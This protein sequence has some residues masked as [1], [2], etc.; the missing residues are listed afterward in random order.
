MNEKEEE[1]VLENEER[2]QDESNNEG[3]IIEKEIKPKNNEDNENQNQ[4][5]TEHKNIIEEGSK[6]S[7]NID[8]KEILEE[9]INENKI[10]EI[11]ND[12]N[13][14]N[15]ENDVKQE[16]KKEI[17]VGILDEIENKDDENDKKDKLEI[18]E[19][20]E[21]IEKNEKKDNDE[22]QIILNI[23]ED[24]IKENNEIQIA[25]NLEKKENNENKENNE[26][27][28]NIDIKENEMKDNNEIKINDN[29]EK[30]KK[31]KNEKNEN[32]EK[33]INI[34][35]LLEEL[36]KKDEIIEKM[37]NEIKN[38]NEEMTKIKEANKKNSLLLK[39]YFE[40]DM[41]SIKEEIS[42]MKNNN[43]EAK[44]NKKNP[45]RK[46]DFDL[47]KE[48]LRDL[49][50]KYN[51]FE[52]VFDNKL[53]FIESSLSK[54]LK[55]EGPQKEE[56]K[57]EKKINENKNQIVEN[58]NKINENKN[59]IVENKN[60]ANV[61][62]NNYINK[63]KPYIWNL[64]DEDEEIWKEFFNFLDVHF[65]EK[66]AK[67]KEIKKADLE[68]F[69]KISLNLIKNGKLPEEK[70]NAYFKDKCSNRKEDEFTLNIIKKKNQIFEALN[71]SE[72]KINKKKE[73]SGFLG[74]GGHKEHKEKNVDV[75]KFNIKKFR[76]EYNLP[77]A[78]FPDNLL[79]Q[80]YVECKG[81]EQALFCSLLK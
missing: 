61:N 5:K 50:D 24:K 35:L 58:K 73:G 43:D 34:K 21:N 16:N 77:E 75:K 26:K 69:K 9:N 17:I 19:K 20:N 49:S 31:A 40:K 81:N 67:Y 28:I 64:K 4:D 59:Q 60:K 72:D 80:K 22:K 42:K 71:E 47:M 15:D 25:D 37:Q 55:E 12:K 27:Q 79:K 45:I 52:R 23:E 74:F 8:K 46:R 10:I 63:D 11:K 30:D 7:G 53:D 57:I 65:S 32:N 78:E 29:L 33:D 18:I 62:D 3:Q 6:N 51:N 38:I 39:N 13:K 56:K 14:K 44:D 36:K 68:R 48:D 54:L 70:F 66:N 76:K 41:N 1:I 2:E